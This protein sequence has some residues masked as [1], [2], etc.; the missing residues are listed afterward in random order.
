MSD[1][2]ARTAKKLSASGKKTK[3]RTGSL[4]KRCSSHTVVQQGTKRKHGAS[5]RGMK[6]NAWNEGNML[7]ALKEF[8]QQA[9]KQA[10]DRLGIR[11]IARSWNVPY[12]TFRKRILLKGASFQSSHMSG[13]PTILSPIEENELA[14][15]IRN[16]AEVG[17]PCDRTDIR[18][19][20]FEYAT[21][22]GVK[23]FTLA[24]KT[25]GYYWFK[26]F[27]ERHPYLAIKK[28]ENLCIA[29]A[30]ALNRQHVD[31]WYDK[32]QEIL[33]R[34][35]IKDV[36]AHLWNVD[37]T[38]CQNIHKQNEVVGVVGQ[39]TYS[40]TAL[41]KGETSTAL[42]AINAVG[43]SPPPMII[44]KGKQLGKQWKNGARHDTLVRASEN[45]Y[46]NK[47]LFQEFGMAFVTYLQKN[48]MTSLPHL[49]VLDSHYSH[50]YNYEFLEMMKTN[51]VHVFA[52]PPHTSHW[53]QPLDVGV[54]RSFKNGWQKAMKEYTRDTAGRKLEKK[55]FFIV[56]NQAWDY[57]VTTENCQGGFRG[58]GLFPF[59]Q[60]AIPAC[61]FAPSATT[62]RP[63]TAL[64]IETSAEPDA[65][66]VPM[67]VESEEAPAPSISQAVVAVSEQSEPS[68]ATD[69]SS[70]RSVLQEPLYQQSLTENPT[71]QTAGDA[72]AS[73]AD[74]QPV[75]Q[76][77]EPE[78][79]PG[80]VPCTETAVQFQ[81]LLPIPKRERSLSKR[82]R[83][84]PPSY[85]LTS[86]ETMEF[87]TDAAKKNRKSA[88]I[89]PKQSEPKKKKRAV[90]TVNKKVKGST[91]TDNTLC[92]NCAHKYGAS[93]DPKKHEDWWSCKKCSKW[94]HSSCAEEVGLL[95]DDDTYY[96]AQCL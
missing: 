70:L 92:S 63:L 72:S 14:N 43:Q 19:L 55:D 23:G 29:R 51:N 87:V 71:T 64:T 95:D 44:H 33:T 85:E 66:P 7:E 16:L 94:F 50:L 74:Q 49:L 36:P 57:G 60:N 31:N 52:I 11:Q 65:V 61:A 80:E 4:L 46:I 12:A 86:K 38:G 75:S 90:P 76:Q 79:L 62:E 69:A 20:A 82:P 40:I 73:V 28:A 58:T 56:F 47:Q 42:I 6:L 24:Q 67:S 32:Y 8:S 41:E 81:A 26:G 77:S 93:D 37:E 17:F 9:E 78:N 88:N 15:H 34:L 25:A 68:R 27:M 1:S 39:P 13:R 45:G 53:L 21:Q 54:F 91:V 83:R 22:K 96:C 2:M 3:K 84:K 30:M 5:H 18:N 89:K 59:N 48:G 10:S 35:G